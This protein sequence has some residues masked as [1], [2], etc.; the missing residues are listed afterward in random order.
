MRTIPFP[1]SHFLFSGFFEHPF[2]WIPNP[3][4]IFGG[5][6]EGKGGVDKM[7]IFLAI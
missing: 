2:L 7:E 3:N 4:M 1:K 5:G 6:Q